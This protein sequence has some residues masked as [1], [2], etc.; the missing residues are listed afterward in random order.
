MRRR[1]RRNRPS[2]ARCCDF[3]RELKRNRGAI[4]YFTKTNSPPCS[5]AS[6]AEMSASPARLFDT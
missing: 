5:A 4:V 2:E 1:N 3:E 6:M